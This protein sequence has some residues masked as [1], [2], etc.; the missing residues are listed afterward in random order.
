MSAPI[1]IQVQQGTVTVQVAGEPVVLEAGDAVAFPGDVPH[2]YANP[3]Q[4]PPGSPWPS[5][6]LG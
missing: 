3:G 6:N 4:E 5:S 2:G 1:V